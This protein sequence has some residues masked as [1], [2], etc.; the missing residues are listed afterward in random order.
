MQTKRKEKIFLFKKKTLWD[1][2]KEFFY[3]YRNATRSEPSRLREKNNKNIRDME[4][5]E[6]M[7]GKGEEVN[8]SIEKLY[9]DFNIAR[10]KYVNDPLFIGLA[11]N[12]ILPTKTY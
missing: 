8:H 9:G 10:D 12:L 4:N 5:I 1:T 2:V 11:Q 7:K 3:G 6:K